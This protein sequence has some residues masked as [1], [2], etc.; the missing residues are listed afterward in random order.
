MGG[1]SGVT[2]T[3]PAS[4][5]AL[6]KHSNLQLDLVGDKNMISPML[7]GVPQSVVS[8][9]GLIHSDQRIPTGKR[10]QSVLRASRGSSLYVAVD[11]VKQGKVGAM[12]SAGDTGA[13]L[14]VG[15]H[16]LKTLDGINKPAILATLPSVT[17]PSYLLD[18]GANPECDCKQLFEFA[19]M[20]TVL[21]E[22]LGRSGPR[23]G[24]L[25]IGSE[26]YKGS[27]AVLQAAAA[28]EQ[29]ADL[30]YI[31]FVEAN[32]LFEGTADVVVCDG[33]VGNVT[34]KSSAGVANVISKLLDGAT[35][36][37]EKDPLIGSLAAQLNP[38]RFNGASLLGLQGSVV[39]SHGN[40]TAEGFFYAIEQAIREIDHGIPQLIG[41]RV[42]DIMS[43]NQGLL[44]GFKN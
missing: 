28:L 38:Q 7:R 37:V 44:T 24:L 8:R 27:S 31:G 32:E 43:S 21:A 3:G 12:V 11:H 14:L 17:E 10:P 13:L 22:S 6:Q 16:L 25:N 41:K 33:F 15:R 26:D 19:V 20:G 39:K 9:L 40:A 30:N 2:V 34:I 23:V 35:S 4:V 42:A 5:R 18:V 36:I 1:D 29:C